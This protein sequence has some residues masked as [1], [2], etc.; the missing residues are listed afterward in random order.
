MRPALA[1]FTVFLTLLSFSALAAASHVVVSSPVRIEMVANDSSVV[2]LGTVGP[3]QKVEVSVARSTGELHPYY[4]KEKLW[5]RLAVVSDSLPAGWEAVDSLVYEDPLKAFVIVGKN[6]PDGEY[7]FQL[8]AVDELEGTAPQTISA[9]VTVSRDV[10]GFEALTPVVTAGGG[11]PA[12]Y[13]FRLSNTGSASDV[14]EISVSSG[15]PSRWTFSKQFFVPW[16]SS[17][18]AQYEVVSE[19]YGR[20]PIRFKAVSLSSSEISKEAQAELVSESSL[21]LEA[22]ATSHGILLFP[23]VEQAVYSLIGFV[24]NVMAY[25]VK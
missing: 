15:L 17:V 13:S 21:Y 12:I 1:F 11:Q 4:G 24:A 18:E 22:R 2:D 10:L 25:F 9:K 7:V 23:S 6:A 8:T 19:E 5:D 20:F 14:F 16:N 3:G